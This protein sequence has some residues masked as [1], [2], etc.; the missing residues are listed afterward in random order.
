MGNGDAFRRERSMI[1]RESGM[2]QLWR[3][4]GIEPGRPGAVIGAS[5]MADAIARV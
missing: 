3:P 4:I 5:A 1:N 2:P